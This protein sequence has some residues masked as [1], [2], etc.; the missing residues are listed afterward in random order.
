[1]VIQR[2]P[3]VSMTRLP[4]T[5]TRQPMTQNA[6]LMLH[7]L[8]DGDAA[9]EGGATRKRILDAA[10]ALFLDF[11][12]RRTT[13]EDVARRAG[14][15]R[16]TVYRAFADKG[17]LVQA[18][19]LRECA[20]AIRDISR[21]LATIDAVD[22]RFIEAFVL[23]VHG[24]RNHPLVQRLFDIEAEWLLPYF[25]VNGGPVLELARNYTAEHFRQAQAQGHFTGVD[26]DDAAELCMRL[27]HSLILMPGNRVSARDEQSLRRYA[28][29]F[30]LPLLRDKPVR[31]KSLPEKSA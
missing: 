18:V 23:T 31:K 30:L 27:F 20:L 5:R 1:M 22:Q 25:T 10:L 29:E 14:T 4:P 9:A 13:I 26:A 17:A 28:G 3:I 6:A 8:I 7:A 24:A 21:Q 16:A 2:P 19:V 11:G 15:G 12:T